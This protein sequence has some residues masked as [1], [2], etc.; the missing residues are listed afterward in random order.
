MCGLKDLKA[1]RVGDTLHELPPPG[2]PPPASLPGF[3]PAKS[4][5]GGVM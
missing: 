3:K 4:M 5:V 2:A 1:A